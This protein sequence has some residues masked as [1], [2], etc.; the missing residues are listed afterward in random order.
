MNAKRPT[1]I[2]EYIA[3]APKVGQAHLRK[4]HLI[5][6][7]VAP[8]AQQTIKWGNP[9]FVQPRFLFAFSAFKAHINFAP[10]PEALEAF[11]SELTTHKTT[12]N[13]LQI[14]YEAPVPESLVRRIAKYRLKAV[15]ARK[16]NGFW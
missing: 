12:R 9:F 14:A 11:R 16:D 2:A 15:S 4:I 8:D 13:F 3:A 1:T 10:G 7:S 6:K 5:L